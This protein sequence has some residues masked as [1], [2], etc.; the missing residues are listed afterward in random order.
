MTVMAERPTT[1]GTEPHSFEDLLRTLDE[2]NVPDGY[3][4]E[5][6]RGNIVVSPWQKAYYLRAMD[7]ICD[8]VRPYLPEGHRI[9]GLPAL[10]V[11]REGER[12]YGPDVHA[13][14]E[15]ARESTSYH[16][17]G[18]ALSFVAELTSTSTRSADLN[19]KVMVYG[20]AGVPVYLLLNM[21]REEATVY[22]VPSPQV[23]YEKSLTKPFGEKLYIPD[24]F[25]FALDT[26]GFHAP[27][28]AAE[29]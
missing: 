13:A 14:H 3:K 10:Y 6:I 21:Q 12:A 1:H 4:A 23:G 28:G 24:P 27:E 18:E 26:T 8:R 15:S 22:S 20:K 11:F 16:L 2:L 9:S 29:S 7:L 17:D 19:D 25:G 5:I